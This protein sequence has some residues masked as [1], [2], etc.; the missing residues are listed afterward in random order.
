M[1]AGETLLRPTRRYTI[2]YR[3]GRCVQV[4]A[5]G[6]WSVSTALGVSSSPSR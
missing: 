1:L 4:D 2:A 6:K 5:E 3:D